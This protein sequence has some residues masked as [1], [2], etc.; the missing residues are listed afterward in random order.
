MISFRTFIKIL[1]FR[2]NFVLK[3]LDV[4]EQQGRAAGLPDFTITSILNQLSV[5][6]AYTP[7]ECKR[8]EVIPMAAIDSKLSTY[9][10][11]SSESWCDFNNYW[12]MKE[13]F[14]MV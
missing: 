11:R 8:V 3:V 5:N 13:A 7:L 2:E 14:K 10:V 12:D 1:L 9:K 6:I 4:L